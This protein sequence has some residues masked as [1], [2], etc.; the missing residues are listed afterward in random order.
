MYICRVSIKGRKIAYLTPIILI[1]LGVILQAIFSE[2][3]LNFFKYPTN[4]I[5]GIELIAFTILIYIFFKNSFFVKYLSS[6]YSA[7]SSIILYSIIVLIKGIVSPESNSSKIIELL[8]LSNIT[9]SW[10]YLLSLSYL[11]ISLSFVT[12]KRLIPFNYKNILFFINH[13]GLL[14]V[15]LSA[16]LGQADKTSLNMMIPEEE[17]AW[18]AFDSDGQRTDLNF[19]IELKELQIET[20]AKDS[21]ATS[22]N[23]IVKVLTNNNQNAY[24]ANIRVNKPININEWKVYLNTHV[25]KDNKHVLV[26]T[27][28][29]DRW[30][31]ITYIGFILVFI[32]A[33]LLIFNKNTKA[34]K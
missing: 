8:S 23:A 14:L 7:L 13:F 17:K 21:S 33:I 16:N 3:N 20:S 11:L 10:F 32:G 22:Y 2:V 12:I 27:L 30:L 34:L 1:V 31:T 28:I 4:L 29:K 9:Y 6:A 19:A 24:D 15:L 25:Y 5:V 18:Y 26:L